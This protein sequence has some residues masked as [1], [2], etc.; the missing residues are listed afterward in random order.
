MAMAEV[1]VVPM[2]TGSPSLSKYVAEVLKLVK[3]SGIKYQLTPMGTILEGD[4]DEIFSLVRLMHEVPFSNEGIKRVVTTLKID[5]RRDKPL[6]M[7][8]KVKAVTSKMGE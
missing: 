2:G 8:S 3:E 7:E 4:L 6:T 1:T 5:D